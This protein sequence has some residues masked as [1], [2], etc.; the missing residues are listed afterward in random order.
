MNRLSV[1]DAV[2]FKV[3]VLSTS[4]SAFL[5]YFCDFWEIWGQKNFYKKISKIFKKN[6]FFCPKIFFLPKSVGNDPGTLDLC[7]KSFFEEKFFFC[8]QAV[9]YGVVLARRQNVK[10]SLFW[11]GLTIYM[12]GLSRF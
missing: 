9:S 6:F 7:Q 11:A 12:N 4:D 8:S 3:D 10:M 5:A 2:F 1:F